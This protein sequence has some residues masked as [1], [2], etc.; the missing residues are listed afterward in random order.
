MDSVILYLPF[1]PSVNDYYGSKSIGK[2]KIVYIKTKGKDYRLDLE[3]ALASQVGYLQREDVLHIEIVVHMPDDRR[4][5]LDNYMKALLDACTHA[6]L[7]MDDSQIEQLCIYRGA[8]ARGGL[9]K[10]T[11][12][13]GGP[14]LPLDG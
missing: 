14:R 3:Q 1:P 4:R 9:I 5:D 10:M 8:K 13:E 7:W 2:K 12:D 11:I 6:K